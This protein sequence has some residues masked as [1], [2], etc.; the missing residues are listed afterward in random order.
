MPEP[1]I[2]QDPTVTDPTNQE[3]DE[4]RQAR[5]AAEAE[6]REQEETEKKPWFK[7]RFDEI[8]RQK[9]AE[10][11]RAE[12]AEKRATELEQ[13]I[14]KLEQS[15]TNEELVNITGKPKPTMREFQEKFDDPDQANEAYY[16]ALSDWKLEQHNAKQ[17]AARK[18][19]REEQDQ[20][21]RKQ[22]ME[23]KRLAQVTAGRAKYDNW[24]Q[25]V[26]TIPDQ[27]LLNNGMFDA[28]LEIGNPDVSYY[29]GQNLQEAERISKLSPYAMAAEIGK[30]E[31]R[32]SN[33]EKKTTTAP[34][35][36]TTLSGKTTTKIE[37]DPEKDLDAWVAARNRGEI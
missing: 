27:I 31:Q 9:Y 35:P 26:H 3:T 21:K 30:I 15:T 16:D 12:A 28:L 10:A 22:T 5:E 1:T 19:E 23:Q 25:V 32:L 8:T 4:Q 20:Q 13:R 33:P 6:Q 17:K 34:E 36:V 37:L 14:K 2:E 18:K 24:D 29:L 11:Q 7:K